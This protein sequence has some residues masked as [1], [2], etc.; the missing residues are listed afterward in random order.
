M[1]RVKVDTE[2][3][4]KALGLYIYRH[5]VQN[6]AVQVSKWGTFNILQN[7]INNEP[8]FFLQKDFIKGVDISAGVFTEQGQIRTLS[9]SNQQGVVRVKQLNY[10]ELCQL[11]QEQQPQTFTLTNKELVKHQVDKL[12]RALQQ[13][14]LQKHQVYFQIPSIGVF[15]IKNNKSCVRFSVGLTRLMAK[16]RQYLKDSSISFSRPTKSI[17]YTTI[18]RNNSVQFNKDTLDQFNKNNSLNKDTFNQTSK[19]NFS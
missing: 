16:N 11:L 12:I 8:V 18:K 17:D 4:N 5:L 9:N 19:E 3:I 2:D 7:Y 10:V 14:Y 6:V 13:E 15:I 1:N